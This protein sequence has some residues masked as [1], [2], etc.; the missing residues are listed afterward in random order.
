MRVEERGDA[1]PLKYV[2]LV[3]FYV[4]MLPWDA[5][6]TRKCVHWRESEKIVLTFVFRQ[7]CRLHS[8]NNC[9]C[10]ISLWFWDTSTL[11][12]TTNIK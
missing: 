9:N 10:V 7:L 6:F 5:D 3:I 12:E 11:P 1:S 2:K 8:N 4:L